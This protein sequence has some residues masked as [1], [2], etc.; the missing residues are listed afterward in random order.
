[1]LPMNNNSMLCCKWPNDHSWSRWL[2]SNFRP[3]HQSWELN[4]KMFW[5][6]LNVRH[7]GMGTL[8]WYCCLTYCTKY[9]CGER[10]QL[11]FINL[12]ESINLNR[13]RRIIEVCGCLPTE[14][15]INA[16]HPHLCF[17]RSFPARHADLLVGW[18]VS[19]RRSSKLKNHI[20]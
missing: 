4:I 17:T 8:N 10:N 16:G 14:K 3:V 7:Y 15:V 2:E 5:S 13:I 9:H 19:I 20:E 12:F 1:M 18:M 6:P 11:Q